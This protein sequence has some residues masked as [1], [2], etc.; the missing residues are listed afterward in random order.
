[1]N[2]QL[3]KDV[4]VRRLEAQGWRRDARKLPHDDPER[5]LLLEKAA[6]TLMRAISTLKREL[7]T[8][9][10]QPVEQKEKATLRELLSQTWGS[11]GGTYRDAKDYEK[12]L[13]SYSDGNEVEEKRRREDGV[14]GLDS[15]NMVQR[16]IVQLRKDPAQLNEEEFLNELDSARKE[17][18][19]QFQLGRRDGWALAD[20]AVIRFL[21]GEA[22]EEI[23]SDL[24]SRN[25]DT[26]FYESTYEAIGALLDEGLGRETP[27]E[28]RLRQFRL[29]LRRR[30]GLK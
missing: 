29:M 30:G 6:R 12:A 3:V 7:Q 11:L 9:E 19:R 13:N 23:V 14:L 10:G 27:L 2:E 1:M 18:D 8:I 5:K 15:Y 28:D 4:T 21:R 24:E 26:S 22:A 20:A 16:L 25:L 17:L